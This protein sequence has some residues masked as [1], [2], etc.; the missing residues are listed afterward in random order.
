[1]KNDWIDLPSGN[2]LNMANVAFFSPVGSGKI[3]VT[4]AAAFPIS[5]SGKLASRQLDERDSAALIIRLRERTI[6]AGKLQ[7]AAKIKPEALL[8]LDVQ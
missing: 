7:E 3:L 2:I 6:D 4:F 1:M 8:N 5:N